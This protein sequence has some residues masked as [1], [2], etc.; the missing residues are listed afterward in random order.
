MTPRTS[1]IEIAGLR[2]SYGDHEVVAGVGLTV[3]AGTVCSG[4]TGPANPPQVRIL[5]TLLP[6]DAGEARVAGYDVRREADQVRA[7]IGVTGLFSAVDELLTGREN[8]RLMA[9]LG[10]LDRRRSES[11]VE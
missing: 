9:D 5:S 4:P 6:A 2:K 11:V 3:P 10:H 7:S 8:L 1:A